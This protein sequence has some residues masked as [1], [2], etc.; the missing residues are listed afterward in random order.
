[1]DLSHILLA[2]RSFDFCTSAR[3]LLDLYMN[4]KL[5]LGAAQ[6]FI[7]DLFFHPQN[8]KIIPV[9]I[10]LVFPTQLGKSCF[11]HSFRVIR[12]WCRARS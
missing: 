3:F 4:F 9:S 6:R 11:S 1:M 5:L 7:T 10:A 8:Y 12:L 2:V